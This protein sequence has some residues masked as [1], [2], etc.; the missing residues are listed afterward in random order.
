VQRMDILAHR[1]KRESNPNRH[2][3]RTSKG[4]DANNTEIG[5]INDKKIF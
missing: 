1:K 2:I 3:A 4:S 5:P